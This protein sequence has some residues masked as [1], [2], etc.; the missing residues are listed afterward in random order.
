MEHLTHHNKAKQP[1]SDNLPG[2]PE[3]DLLPFE[4][5]S[6]QQ[7]NKALIYFDALTKVENALANAST[8]TQRAWQNAKR[9]NRE[10]EFLNEIAQ[11]A[12]LS[13]T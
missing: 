3:I 8:D 9:F 11:K 1:A 10:D 6:R 13:R 12:D 7:L 5:I 4:K 2:L